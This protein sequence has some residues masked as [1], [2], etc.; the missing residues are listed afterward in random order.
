[1]LG[2][3]F[4]FSQNSETVI[5]SAIQTLPTSDQFMKEIEK[6]EGQAV[7]YFLVIMSVT[8]VV[9]FLKGLY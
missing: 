9:S 3:Y 5:F 4:Q 6:Y 8:V 1:M 7:N 2:M